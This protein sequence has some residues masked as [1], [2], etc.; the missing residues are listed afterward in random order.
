MTADSSVL[1]NRVFLF[2]SDQCVLFMAPRGQRKP[3]FTDLCKGIVP[4]HTHTHTPTHAVAGSP[5]ALLWLVMCS[6]SGLCAGMMDQLTDGQES[7]PWATG[8]LVTAQP[9]QTPQPSSISRASL[10]PL[11]RPFRPV[12]LNLFSPPRP[13][14]HLFNYS[15]LHSILL[16]L[17]VLWRG[18]VDCQTGA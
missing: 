12:L 17:K 3:Q 5:G 6:R 8:L 9:C 1:I 11:P 13:L 4:P 14:S 16:L 18:L 7:A 10:P 2:I 15:S